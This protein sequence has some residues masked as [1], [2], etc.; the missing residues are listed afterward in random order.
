MGSDDGSGGKWRQ[1]VGE[2]RGGEGCIEAGG[3]VYLQGHD[4]TSG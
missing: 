2:G 3:V 4:D 1:M